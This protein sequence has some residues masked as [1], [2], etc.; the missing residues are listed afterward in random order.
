MGNYTIWRDL[1]HRSAMRST[2]LSFFALAGSVSAQ[3][4]AGGARMMR[5][6]CSQLV[7]E[8][9]DPLVNPGQVGTPHTHQIIGGNSFRA[10]MKPV[11]YDLPSHSTCTSCTF[12]EVCLA[13]ELHVRIRKLIYLGFLKL[14]DRSTIL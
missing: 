14:L 12:A 4:G 8:R 10:D 5:F 11:E 3:A 1:T 13:S 7:V 2:T 6:G 9:L